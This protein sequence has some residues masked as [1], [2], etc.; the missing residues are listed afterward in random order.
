[1]KRIALLILASGIVLPAQ[2]RR[3]AGPRELS[4][5]PRQTANFQESVAP[6][7]RSALVDPFDRVFV[8]VLSG[9]GWETLMTFVNMS[10]APAQFTLTFYD[11]NGNPVKVP[12]T[13]PDGSVSRFAAVNFLMDGN[14]SQE[15][16]VANV[17]NNVNYAWTYLSFPGNTAPIAGM[18]VVRTYDSSG[19][20]FNETTETLSNIRDY[21]FFAPYDN[22]QG[23]ATGLIVLNP[24][25]SLTAT[26]RISAQDA[27]GNE[28]VRDNFLLAPG[29]RT[30]IMLP[31]AYKVLTGT[32]GKLRVVGDTNR[33]SAIVF[34]IS[35]ASN[36]AYSPIFNWSGMFQ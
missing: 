19:N 24:S 33:L 1:M 7:P 10:N 4:S 8:D 28:L 11:D 5:V 12:L 32:S 25:A 2:P 17:D 35:P 15:L 16:V 31:D 20:I 6:R 36:M 13:N 18:A 23:I 9:G 21:D 3:T 34:R 29:A 30:T 14:T 26:V 27:N 22:V